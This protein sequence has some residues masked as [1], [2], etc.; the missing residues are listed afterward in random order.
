MRLYPSQ[1]LLEPRYERLKVNAILI[2]FVSNES[3]PCEEAMNHMANNKI[4]KLLWWNLRPVQSALLQPCDIMR[5]MT[6]LKQSFS[7]RW[8][9]V[10]ASNL[11]SHGTISWQAHGKFSIYII[12]WVWRF[13]NANPYLFRQI[14]LVFIVFCSF[15]SFFLL[16]KRQRQCN[17]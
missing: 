17:S 10:L 16:I 12:M 1:T 14:V 2:Q 3:F 15:L 11:V 7:F 4:I 5:T 9:F 6:N 8:K 13:C